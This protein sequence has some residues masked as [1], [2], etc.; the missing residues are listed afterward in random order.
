MN[1]LSKAGLMIPV[2]LLAKSLL[3]KKLALMGARY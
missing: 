2:S 3:G 1:Q